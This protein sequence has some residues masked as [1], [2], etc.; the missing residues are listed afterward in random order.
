MPSAIVLK[1]VSLFVRII[2][3][4]YEVGRALAPRRKKSAE[5]D[6]PW[7]KPGADDRRSP[8]P[9]V[10]A[11]AN[12][13]YL[14]RDGK[15]V[16]LSQLVSAFKDAINFEQGAI[17]LV[18]LKARE[19]ST[20]GN[21]LTI[22][23]DDLAKHGVIEH[24]G[25][26]SRA[27]VHVGDNKAFS[28]DIWEFVAS[29]FTDETI[30]IETAARAR[31]ARLARAKETDPQFSMTKTEEWMSLVET[32][33]YLRVFGEGTEGRARREWVRVLFQQERLPFA[34]GFKRSEKV[35]TLGDLLVLQKKLE[36]AKGDPQGEER[37]TA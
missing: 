31:K 34:E 10:N 25:S 13:G 30:S 35:I 22:H 16:S 8:C 24:D 20:T 6:H 23:L 18:G 7:Q 28:P 17:L 9:M 21:P 3:G 2:T 12:H 29:H 32:C 4:F 14:P 5:E 26:L 1:V 15:N 33:L 27:D 36:E 37:R 19:T 11:L